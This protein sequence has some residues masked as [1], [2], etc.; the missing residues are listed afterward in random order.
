MLD[1][2]SESDVSLLASNGAET[3]GEL[4]VAMSLKIRA[5]SVIEE[6]GSGQ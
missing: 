2:V 4:F 3:E 6:H 1:S 5:R